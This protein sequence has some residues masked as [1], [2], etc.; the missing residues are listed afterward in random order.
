M[1]EA[2]LEKSSCRAKAHEFGVAAGK[3][4]GAE[5][6]A[7]TQT[8]SGGADNIRSAVAAMRRAILSSR[9]QSTGSKK[10]AVTTAI[11][12]FRQN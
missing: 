5:E 6:R 11:L 10:V 4:S 2:H 9:F 3:G 7:F 8:D 12:F 1:I